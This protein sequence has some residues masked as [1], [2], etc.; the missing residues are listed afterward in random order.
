M[1]ESATNLIG[2]YLIYYNSCNCAL[3]DES[4][5]IV[6]HVE[7]LKLFRLITYFLLVMSFAS[8]CIHCAAFDRNVLRVFIQ[9]D[10][11]LVCIDT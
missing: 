3:C 6:H 8:L 1:F 11:R 10:W 9:L 2:Y 4:P 5:W 7:S